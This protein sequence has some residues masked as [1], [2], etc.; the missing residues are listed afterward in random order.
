[1]DCDSGWRG[2][3]PGIVQSGVIVG[4]IAHSGG[5]EVWTLDWLEFAVDSLTSQAAAVTLS[6]VTFLLQTLA[7]C[8][9]FRHFEQI[10]S[11]AGHS[12]LG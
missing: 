4:V 7:K 1:M 10:E 11:L 8:P 12:Y 3:W 5:Q 2:G 9:F 6:E